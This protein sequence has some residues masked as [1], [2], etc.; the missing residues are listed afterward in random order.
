VYR[1]TIMLGIVGDSATGKTT[2]TKGLV[3]IFG[4]DNVVAL[5]SDDYHRY[6]RQQRKENGI[7]ALD[8]RCNYIDIMEQHFRLLRE[9]QP[10]LKPIYNHSTGTFDPPEYIQPTKFVIIEGLLGFHSRLLRDCFDIKVY[11]SPP[12][13][14]RYEWKIK[15]D[16]SKRG[17][18]RNQVL[19]ALESRKEDSPQFITPQRKFGDIVVSFYPPSDNYQET[20]EHLNVKLI[21]RPTIPHPDLSDILEHA[22]NGNDPK[23]A[24]SLR[25]DR[26]DGKPVDI[27]EV[28]GGIT[29][30]KTTELKNLLWNYLMQKENG[31]PPMTLGAYQ[32]RQET[33]YSY[34]LIITQLLIA[35]HMSK[36]LETL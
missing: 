28:D 19:A 29:K 11:L 3:N 13:P 10:I 2:L 33:H 22:V 1:K 9:G 36:A 30:E 17:Y 24:M 8:P 26:S 7:T 27:L 21:L 34:P 35:Y 4:A 16:M 31:L 25:L 23:P 12:E 14:L 20:G 15:R 6:D 18:T 5:C 32:D